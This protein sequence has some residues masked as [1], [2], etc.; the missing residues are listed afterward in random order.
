M[1]KISYQFTSAILLPVASANEE[2][3]EDSMTI[4]C[5]VLDD[6]NDEDNMFNIDFIYIL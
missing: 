2:I 5:W 4:P 1:V 3:G 6:E